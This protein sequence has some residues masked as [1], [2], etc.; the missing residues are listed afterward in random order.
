MALKYYIMKKA[1]QGFITILVAITINF[2]L[3]NLAPGNP[4]QFI[5]GDPIFLSPQLVEYYSKLW[6]LDK[7]VYVRYFIY[8]S[9]LFR[10]DLG[11]SYRYSAPVAK[12]IIERLP[13]TLLL[14][15]VADIIAFM[16]G[17]YLGLLSALKHRSV[18]D[19]SFTIISFVFNSM[20]SF[21]LGI[22]LILIF[23]VHLRIFPVSGIMDVRNPKTGIMLYLDI[24][25]HS[26]LPVMTLALILMPSYFKTV[27]DAAIQQLGED[28]VLTFRAIG[29]DEWNIFKRHIFRNVILPPV[30]LFVINLGYSV[31]GAAIVETVFGW[32]GIGRLLLDSI[33]QRDYPVVMGVYLMV[34][35]SVVVMNIIADLVYGILDPR[36]KTGSGR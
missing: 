13:I 25:Y 20:P 7:P 5:A 32:P 31:A 33:R 34:T 22:I 11:Y 9:N 2:F 30:T 21:L 28:Y 19:T 16:L 36:I 35:S 24:L 17:V 18:L 6:G 1:L 27:R 14:T 29:L 3:I 23:G 4:I 26:I 10:G 8:I 15:V 12:L